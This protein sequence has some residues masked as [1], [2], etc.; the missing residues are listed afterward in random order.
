MANAIC[1]LGHGLHL[2]RSTQL[3]V[4]LGSLN[5]VPASSGVRVG[6]SPRPGGM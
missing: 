2:T 5:L 6:M 3:C 1:S 4:P